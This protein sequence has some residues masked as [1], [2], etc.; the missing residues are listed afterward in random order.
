MIPISRKKYKEFRDI[1]L[2]CDNMADAINMGN[3]YCKS[4]IEMKCLAD[5]LIYGR[6]YNTHIGTDMIIELIT[7]ISNCEYREDGEKIV[8]ETIKER[9]NEPIS[10]TITRIL[11]LKPLKPNNSRMCE[12]FD[13]VVK[14]CPHCGYTRTDINGTESYVVCGYNE[15][16][17]DSNGCGHDWCMK[18]GKMLC[19]TWIDNKLFLADNRKHNNECCMKYALLIKKKYPDDFCMCIDRNESNYDF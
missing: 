2:G 4:N 8:N 19:K 7:N 10:N 17:Y 12:L 5:S 6:D 3:I 1:F 16:G 13:N 9:M 18:C 15:K 14:S 11:N